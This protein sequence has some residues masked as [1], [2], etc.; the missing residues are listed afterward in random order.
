MPFYVYVPTI[1]AALLVGFGAA[2]LLFRRRQGN[3][4]SALEVKAQQALSEAE[5]QAK[6]KL[7][8]AK[9]TEVHGWRDRDRAREVLRADRRR[10]EQELDEGRRKRSDRDG[11]SKVGKG[12]A[13]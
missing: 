7:L 2:Y 11:P 9:E 6:E 12:A 10:F 4:T 5:T 1:V 3:G 8:E 13:R